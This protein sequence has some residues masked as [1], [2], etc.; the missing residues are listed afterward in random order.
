LLPLDAVFTVDVAVVDVVVVAELVTRA[1]DAVVALLLLL[2]YEVLSSD[3]RSLIF[4]LLKKNKI[5]LTTVSRLRQDT[6]IAG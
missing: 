5:G 6:V 1:E 2:L 3:S 4:W